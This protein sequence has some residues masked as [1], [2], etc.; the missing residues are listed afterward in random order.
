MKDGL[1]NDWYCAQIYRVLDD[2]IEVHWFT[3]NTA[4]LENYSTA[5][6]DARMKNLRNSSFL[7]TWCLDYGRGQATTKPPKPTR[8]LKEIYSGRIPISE[9]DQHLLIRNVGISTQGK[10]GPTTLQL[11]I[12]LKIPHHLG[13]GGE[14]D[15][16]NSE[17]FQRQTKQTTHK[18]K[19]N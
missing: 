14:D 10:L 15:F 3:T 17:A 1:S 16:K 18:R 19:R 7:R 12:K 11:A 5:S 9:L 8:R 4:P 13:A 6:P 2:R